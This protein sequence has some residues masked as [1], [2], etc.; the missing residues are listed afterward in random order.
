MGKVNYA[1]VIQDM[2]W[3]YSRI[4]SFCDCRYRWYLRYIRKLKAKDMFFANYGSFMHKLIEMY[5]KGEG[6]SRQLSNMYL[7]KFRE[8]VVGS[9]PNN[10]VF[11]NYF[12]SGLQYLRELQPFPYNILAVEK[13]VDFDLDGIPFVGYIDLLAERDGNLYII[14]NKSKMLKP[15]S[16]NRNPTKNDEELDSYLKQLY[17][18]SIA[19]EQEYQEFP[20]ALC[21]NCFRTPIFIQE[22]FEKRAYANSK[23]WFSDKV[24]QI[25]N[26]TDFKPNIEFFKCKYLCEMNEHCEYYRLSNGGNM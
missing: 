20:K 14:D 6:T 21:F 9:A 7:Q 13:K 3:S 19:I 15:R 23:V 1:P 24:I 26:E 12:K 22:R 5:L 10:K 18:Y 2:T 8:K 4:K 17:L 11:E 25:T 16:K